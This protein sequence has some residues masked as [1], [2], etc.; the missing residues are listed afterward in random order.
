MPDHDTTPGNNVVRV[1]N[2]NPTDS[3]DYVQPVL[4]ELGNRC[5]E[6]GLALDL[7][8]EGVRLV[9]AALDDLGVGPKVAMVRLDRLTALVA[10]VEHRMCGAYFTA[11]GATWRCTVPAGH[12]GDHQIVKPSAPPSVPSGISPSADGTAR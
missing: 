9:L 1:L 10:P 4:D 6:R 5:D 2:G 3:E 7:D 12:D 11:H 8:D